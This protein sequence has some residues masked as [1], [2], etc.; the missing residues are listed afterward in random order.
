MTTRTQ[1][2]AGSLWAL[3]AFALLAYELWELVESRYVL[4]VGYYVV[5]WGLYLLA[6][7]GGTA[8]AFGYSAGRWLILF[9]ATLAVLNELVV[10]L[11]YG[12]WPQSL[13]II[14]FSIAVSI[15]VLRINQNE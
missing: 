15:V 5:G 11:G 10:A 12:V 2:I 9:T 6:I 3:A 13:T 4:S 1:R 7:I 8:V 14:A